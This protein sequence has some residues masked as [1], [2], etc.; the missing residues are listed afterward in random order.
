[1]TS[2]T[3]PR[4]ALALL[5]ALAACV[6]APG[7][8][9]AGMTSSGEASSSTSAAS[10]SASMSSTSAASTSTA[11]TSASSTSDASASSAAS[12]PSTDGDP[13]C[14]FICQ[15]D[16]GPA[17]PGL[18]CDFFDPESCPE[19]HKCTFFGD[20]WTTG[21]EDTKCVPITGDGELG[22]ACKVELP[23]NSGLD[24][25]AAHHMCWD[26][27]EGGEGHCVGVC[28]GSWDKPTCPDGQALILGRTLCLCFPT[29]DPIAPECDEGEVCALHNE[30]AFVCTLDASEGKHP[31][32]TP[33]EFINECN[34]GSMCVDANALPT[35]ACQGASG[36]CAPFCDLNQGSGADNPACAPLA[37]EVPGIGCHAFFSMPEPGQE[38]I[39]VCALP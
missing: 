39:G 38:H 11:S 3:G 5:L 29:C 30:S 32:G 20:E 8:S 25:C 23:A 4:L 15:P 9:S 31:P 26:A 28:G 13:S 2:A 34:P 12:E 21:W 35:D 17:I 18:H 6:P 36:C 22:D 16:M 14:G 33:C 7:D 1:M 19:G 37:G 10:G 27:D 24:D